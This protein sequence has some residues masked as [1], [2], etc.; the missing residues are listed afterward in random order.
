[1]E[2]LN[3]YYVLTKL[4][5][6]Y[7]VYILEDLSNLVGFYEFTGNS[8]FILTDKNNLYTGVDTTIT[9]TEVKR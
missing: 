6:E 9:K 7:K 4:K 5:N 8:A 3:L 2:E 1:M